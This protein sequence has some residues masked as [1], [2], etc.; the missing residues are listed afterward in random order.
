MPVIIP[1]GYAQ[2]TFEFSGP[3]VPDG[4]GAIVFGSTVDPG[5]ASQTGPDWATAFLGLWADIG[6]EELVFDRV[7]TVTAASSFEGIVDEAGGASG[8]PAP[9]NVSLLLKKATAVRGRRAQGRMFPPGVLY[10]E[11]ILAGGVINPDVVADRTSRFTNWL[12]ASGHDMVILQG[13]EGTSPP[14]SPPPVVS[15][16]ICDARISTQ[17]KRLR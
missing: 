5:D 14:L 1:N 11:S 3:L 6:S 10:E 16:L 7:L 17:R 13:S 2:I 15:A 9:P 4:I 8:T 12:S